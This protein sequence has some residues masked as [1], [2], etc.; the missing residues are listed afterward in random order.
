[1][2]G[3]AATV[4]GPIIPFGA[5]GFGANPGG[6]NPDELIN[7]YTGICDGSIPPSSGERTIE[8]IF[9]DLHYY[10]WNTAQL[11]TSGWTADSTIIFGWGLS[12]ARVPNTPEN[13]NASS[14]RDPYDFC[15]SDIRPILAREAD[16]RGL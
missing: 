2:L 7:Q 12:G 10:C 14:V 16:D 6:Q 8:G 11:P 13:A 3:I 9:D 1:M 5:P 15:L 4:T